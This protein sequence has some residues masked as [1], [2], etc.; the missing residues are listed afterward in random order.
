M[1]YTILFLAGDRVLRSTSWDAGLE[2]AKQYACEH[3]TIRDAQR[4]EV[5]GDAD[6]IMF[7]HSASASFEVMVS[8][9]EPGTRP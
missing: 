1:N 3:L 6:Q 9:S 7:R 8:R 2:A 5:W 4:V